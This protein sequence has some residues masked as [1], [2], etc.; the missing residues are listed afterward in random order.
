MLRQCTLHVVIFGKTL[1]AR[2]LAQIRWGVPE[3]IGARWRG[4]GDL[5]NSKLAIDWL[6]WGFLWLGTSF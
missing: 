3:L 4:T 5:F 2:I 1:N 6:R